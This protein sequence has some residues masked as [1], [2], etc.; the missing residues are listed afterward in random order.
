MLKKYA[1]II[2]TLGIVVAILS[3]IGGILLAVE[4]E[5]VWYFLASAIS[6]TLFCIFSLAFAALLD[7]TENNSIHLTK[8]EGEIR[9]Q[10][11]PA[12]TNKPAPAV[13]SKTDVAQPIQKESSDQIPAQS[14][15]TPLSDS[16]GYIVCPHCGERQRANRTKCWNCAA[17]FIK[18]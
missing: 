9:K 14:P 13:A 3:V 12:T 18:E 11:A 7:E 8:I 2:R 10:P 1:S 15:V 17:P 4:L 6:A 5:S 16:D